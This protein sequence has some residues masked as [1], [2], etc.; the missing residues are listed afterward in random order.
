MQEKHKTTLIIAAVAIAVVLILYGCF[1]FVSNDE[2]FM[3]H[4]FPTPGDVTIKQIT[5]E[6]LARHPALKHSLETLDP[7]FVTTNPFALIRFGDQC[8]NKSESIMIQ[9]EFGVM[10]WEDGASKPSYRRLLW[11]DTYYELQ[12]Y[13]T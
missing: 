12:G 11:N 3:I 10:Y 13:I 6:D 7:I 5:D 8:V 2:G 4:S 1:T 9:N